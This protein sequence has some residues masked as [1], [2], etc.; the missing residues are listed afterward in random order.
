[1][2]M[3]KKPKN[4]PTQQTDKGL[5]IPVPTRDDIEDALAAIAKP[6]VSRLTRMRKPKKKE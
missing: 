2:E 1:M 4:E 5:T 6:Q 3:D